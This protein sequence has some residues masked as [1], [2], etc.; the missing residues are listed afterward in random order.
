MDT[1]T[2]PQTTPEDTLPE[3]RSCSRC[4]GI[5][6]LVTAVHGMGKYRCDHCDMVVGFDL[7]GDPREFLL[8][9]GQPGAYTLDVFGAQLTGPERR[10]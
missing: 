9:R 6:H 7:E 10:L 5:Q 3:Q 8:D 4:D 2:H 1:T